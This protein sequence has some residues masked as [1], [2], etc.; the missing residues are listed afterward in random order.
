VLAVGGLDLRALPLRERKRLLARV[1]PGRGLIRVLDHLEGDGR[2]L[3]DFCVQQELA[4]VIAKRT[5]SPYVLGPRASDDWV[6][7]T[8]ERD[9]DRA[10]EERIDLVLANADRAH[11]GANAARA[12]RVKLS[13][14]NKVFWPDEGYTKGELCA[15]YGAVADTLLHYLRDRPVLMV[16]YPDGIAGKH[17]FQWNIPAGTPDWVRGLM[18]RSEESGDRDVMSILVEDRDTLLYMAN[19]GCIPLHILA[20]RAQDLERCDF[21]TIDF[22]LG[23]SPLADAIELARGLHELLDQI[24]LTGYPKTSGQTGLHVL[25]ALGGVPFAAAKALAELLGRILHKRFPKISTIER[26]RARRPNAV[27]IDTGQTGRA[28]AIVAPY[29]VRAIAG[30][31]VSTPLSWDEV[32]FN[33]DPSIFTMFTVPERIARYGD[34]MAELLEQKPD[35]GRAVEALGK[36]L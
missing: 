24:G 3:W 23:P 9:D 8:R 4:G 1:V 14:Q 12:G 11:H 18:V 6:A 34:P 31:R 15:Y 27:Y 33:L 5:D 20:S 21:L 16:R 22:D 36:L 19:L 32:G 30:A 35:V 28:R 17:F 7:I 26:M 29:S 13:N 2:L 25:V 10:V